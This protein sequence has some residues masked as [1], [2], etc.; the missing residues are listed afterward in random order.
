MLVGNYRELLLWYFHH[1]GQGFHHISFLESISS[2]IEGRWSHLGHTIIFED[3][4]SY[5]I[6][7]ILEILWLRIH[8]QAVYLSTRCLLCLKVKDHIHDRDINQPDWQLGVTLFRDSRKSIQW[9]L[10]LKSTHYLSL[11][12]PH[13][14][15]QD[16]S[17][18]LYESDQIVLFF[19]NNL[20]SFYNIARIRMFRTY[21]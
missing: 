20:M 14:W 9:P 8:P 11:V 10:S 17:H 19:M 2:N 18:S 3:F 6:C 21:V 1:L 7:D 13:W 4:M 16:L 12:S 5:L 15:L